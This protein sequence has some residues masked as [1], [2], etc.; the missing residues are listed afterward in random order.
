MV[1][2]VVFDFSGYKAYLNAWLK[3]QPKA[4]HGKRRLFAEA[5]GTQT[6]FIT[7]VL[8]GAAHFS[9]EQCLALKEILGLS[10]EEAD[11]LLLLHAKERAGTKSYREHLEA[12]INKTLTDR[13]KLAHRFAEAPVPSE[14]DHG[15]YF[16]TWI[17]AGVHV[18]V[19]CVELRDSPTA[20]AEHLGLKL[21]VVNEALEF[22]LRTGLIERT[23]KGYQT[24]SARLH[25]GTDSPFL[26]RHHLNWNLLA[27][28]ALQE[29]PLDRDLHYSSVVSLSEE[30]IPRVREVFTRALEE[31]KKIVRDS[32]GEKLFAT[33]L[34]FLS[35][36][37][38]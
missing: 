20:I 26:R 28:Q 13:Q 11:F 1:S 14:L 36:P 34:N 24:G 32:E 19:T 30:D 2:P 7:Q 10:V 4:G 29:R 37:K 23:K 22:L 25:L 3:A 21:S 18:A 27:V 5:I 17:Y 9:S 16:S 12:R 31:A 8:S 33:T 38:T 6:G 15:T 35:L